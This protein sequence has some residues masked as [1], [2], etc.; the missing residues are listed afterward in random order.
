MFRAD[1]NKIVRGASSGKADETFKNLS[2]FK[3][4]KNDKSEK[5]TRSSDIG[6]TG[7]PTFLT[8]SAKHAFN[9]LRQAFVKAPI[10]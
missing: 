9:R 2:K 8:P 5:L 7:E 3:K 4:L 10:L 6:A 1:G